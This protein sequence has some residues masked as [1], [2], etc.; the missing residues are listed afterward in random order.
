[1]W[2]FT[3]Y[4]NF[5]NSLGLNTMQ[6]GK[7]ST[8][9]GSLICFQKIPGFTRTHRT[10]ITIA[11]VTQYFKWWY[12]NISP[13][14]HIL[15]FIKFRVALFKGLLKLSRKQRTYSWQHSPLLS[16]SNWV[17]RCAHTLLSSWCACSCGLYHLQLLCSN[18]SVSIMNV[19]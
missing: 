4:W 6:F 11:P 9:K 10:R 18:R 8:F 1:M 15:R 14:I 16:T 17:P 13:W 5:D 3:D 7:V 2:S 12:Q 19:P